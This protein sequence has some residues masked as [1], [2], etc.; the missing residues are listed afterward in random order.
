MSGNPF[1][2]THHRSLRARCSLPLLSHVYRADDGQVS[3]LRQS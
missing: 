2:P 3:D 1:V